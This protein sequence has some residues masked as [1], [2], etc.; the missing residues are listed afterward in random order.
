MNVVLLSDIFSEKREKNEKL[1]KWSFWSRYLGPYAVKQAIKNRCPNK[2]VA[3][4]DY[5][6]KIE[7]FFSYAEDGIIGLD[8]EFIGI[9]T[10]FL[11]NTSNKRVNDFN[12]WFEDHDDIVDWLTELKLIA[13]NAKIFVGG[14]SVDIWYKR[15]VVDPDKPEMPEAM[16]LIDCFIHGYGESSVPDYINGTTNLL[17]VYSRDDVMFI[18][19]GATAGSNKTE[20][21]RVQWDNKDYIQ[22]NEWLSLEISKG[23]KFGCKF[24]MFDK[25]GTTLKCKEELRK[26]LIHNYENFGTVGYQLTD[27]TVNDSL[28]KVKMIHEVFTSLPFK[29]EWIGYVRPDMFH[30]YP[31]MLDML[32]ESGC[33]GVFLG[34]ET[35]NHTAAKIVGKGLDPQKIKNIVKWMK[36]T[37]GDE[38]FILGSFI[39]GLVGETKESLDDT[40][41]YLVN[42]KS[43]DKILWEVLYLRPPDYRTE[44]KDDFNNNN[45]KYG[46]RKLQFKPYYWEH[47]TL[48]YN[49][50]VDISEKW[51]K[52][53]RKGKSGFNKA[54]EENTNFFSYPRMRSLGYTHH[55]SFTML[56]HGNMP[57]ELY[58]K[59]DKWI[60]NYHKGLMNALA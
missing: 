59:N 38:M 19:D 55:E 17:N 32:I 47:N 34:I 42:Q 13:P 39:I 21:L 8:T 14:H 4:I 3:V 12:L 31:E 6:L 33:R 10:T 9:S 29:I 56:K 1:G 15:Y 28:D 52:E 54:L 23:C 35:F 50:C 5:F 51:K 26:E 43:I 60:Y 16:K 27:D 58:E 11:N 40:L 37:T 22:Q 49:Q 24:C 30:R 7:D 2:T 20:C 18:S 48:N 25:M 45:D 36:D 57:P 44:A 41:E 46:I 53:L